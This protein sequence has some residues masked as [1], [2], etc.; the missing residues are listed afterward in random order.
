MWNN[1]CVIE[2]LQVGIGAR[3][4]Q[5]RDETGLTQAALGAEINVAARTVQS[6]E[7]NERT[8]RLVQLTRLATRTGKPVSWFYETEH[9]NGA[10]A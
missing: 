9:T 8:P 6:W 1:T 3:I 5:A 4:K 2:G 7:L 10:A